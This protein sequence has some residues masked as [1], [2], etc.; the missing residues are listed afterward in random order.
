MS[1]RPKKRLVGWAVGLGLLT[2]GAGIAAVL[3]SDGFGPLAQWLLAAFVL[4]L[5]PAWLLARDGSAALAHRISLFG[6]VVAITGLAWLDGSYDPTVLA[7]LSTLPVF[8]LLLSGRRTALATAAVCLVVLTVLWFERT[9][10]ERSTP[11]ALAWVSMV[12]MTVNLL[13]LA[14]LFDAWLRRSNA[15]LARA[16]EHA[17]R[18]TA[19]SRL[20][21]PAWA[22]ACA[23]R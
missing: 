2:I 5:I 9:G 3:A 19:R 10:A 7:W 6:G 14:W 18:P 13:G 4:Q 16:L 8:G 11:A 1:G 12:A 22:T 23:R 17:S 15:E 21:S 20:C